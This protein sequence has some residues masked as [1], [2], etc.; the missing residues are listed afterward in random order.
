[1][2]RDI[3][4]SGDDSENQGETESSFEAYAATEAVDGMEER[5]KKT[6]NGQPLKREVADA[7]GNTVYRESRW[8]QEGQDPSADTIAGH[9]QQFFEYDDQG[10]QVEELGQTLSTQEGDPK[11]ENQWRVSSE[12]GEGGEKTQTGMIESGVDAGHSWKMERKVKEDFGDGRRILI[13]TNEILEQGKNP[14]KAEAGP[15]SEK[16]KFFDGSKW[17]GDKVTNMQT[18][19]VSEFLASGVEKLPNWSK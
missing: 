4:P 19:E 15:V 7:N 18:G 1:M 6:E 2:N 8:Y 5:T 14:E 17:V 11:H 10:R 16:L 13:E 12:Y 9:R 3:P